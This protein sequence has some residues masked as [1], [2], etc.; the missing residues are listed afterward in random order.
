MAR[1][2]LS[3]DNESVF[4]NEK[5]EKIDI[6]SFVSYVNSLVE[7][8]E[9]TEIQDFFSNYE[10]KMRH[11]LVEKTLENLI[12]P[13]MNENIDD[14]IGTV[15]GLSGGNEADNACATLLRKAIYLKALL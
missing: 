8:E 5:S 14:L 3:E 1:Y 11:E 2:T 6:K 10:E 9:L 7:T 4:D 13:I 15:D 12:L